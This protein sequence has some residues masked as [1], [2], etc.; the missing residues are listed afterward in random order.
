MVLRRQRRHA[1]CLDTLD[2]FE[3]AHWLTFGQRV[4]HFILTR[5]CRAS[6]NVGLMTRAQRTYSARFARVNPIAPLNNELTAIPAKA[7]WRVDVSFRK[8]AVQSRWVDFEWEPVAA[9]IA[10]SETKDP[11]AFEAFIDN[12]PRWLWRGCE[13]DFHPSEGEGYWLNLTSDAP[14]V[15]VMWRMDEGDEVPRPVVV[16]ASYNEAG[17]ML[18]AGD[19][20]DKVPMDEAMQAA[21][22]EYTMKFYKPEVR[23]KV[24]RNDPFRDQPGT[25]QASDPVAKVVAG[26][27]APN[28]LIVPPNSPAARGFDRG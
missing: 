22:A 10:D 11:A 8:R 6:F 26:L 9:T 19:R 12:E 15:F 3:G 23:K 21:L 1:A 24:K 2:A 14:C 18:D 16:T 27:D 17:R 28:E 20:V 13:M 7:I 5:F 4:N 25:R